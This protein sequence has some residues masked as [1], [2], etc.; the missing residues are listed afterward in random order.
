MDHRLTESTSFLSFFRNRMYEV[1]E[2]KPSKEAHEKKKK[3]NEQTAL[4]LRGKTL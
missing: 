3:E 2:E 1:S 4:M